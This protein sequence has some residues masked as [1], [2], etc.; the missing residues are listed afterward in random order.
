MI[1]MYEFL[2]K[3][4]VGKDA[5]KT[6]CEIGYDEMCACYYRINTDYM[7]CEEFPF[8]EVHN[9]TYLSK[10]DLVAAPY[11]TDAVLWLMQH[12]GLAFEVA[13][14]KCKE[15]ETGFLYVVTLKFLEGRGFRVTNIDYQ[16]ALVEAV[17]EFLKELIDKS[18]KDERK[19][20]Q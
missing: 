4:P 1:A 15:S 12:K 17:D 7:G 13:T 10:R 5:A 3:Q 19:N 11:V 18:I 2:K 14:V 9:N 8:F 6:L 20:T 16:K